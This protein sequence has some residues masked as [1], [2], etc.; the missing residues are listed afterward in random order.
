MLNRMYSSVIFYVK[1]CRTIEYTECTFY[2]TLYLMWILIYW[3]SEYKMKSEV[4]MYIC[5]YTL[6][7][8][9]LYLCRVVSYLI[10]SYPASLIP[11]INLT[12]VLRYFHFIWFQYQWKWKSITSSNFILGSWS[13]SWSW[14]SRT[15]HQVVDVK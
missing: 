11:M 6:K 14:M 2:D 12:T 13:W 7:Y 3:W 1:Y 8:Y 10:L 15:C 4:A 9:I 5:M